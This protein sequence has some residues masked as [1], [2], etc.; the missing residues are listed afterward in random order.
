[1][2]INITYKEMLGLS[3]K[4]ESLGHERNPKRNKYPKFESTHKSHSSAS[5]IEAF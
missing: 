4:L 3:P 1:M 2:G 5:A